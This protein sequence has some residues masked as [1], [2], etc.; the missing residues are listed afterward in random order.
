MDRG[1]SGETAVWQA[2]KWQR[3]VRDKTNCWQTS[4]RSKDDGW[5]KGTLLRFLRIAVQNWL[6]W[7]RMGIKEVTSGNVDVLF[8]TCL[9]DFRICRC[10]NVRQSANC[11]RLG[12]VVTNKLGTISELEFSMTGFTRLSP[13]FNVV[14]PISKWPG[15]LGVTNA[16]HCGGFFG[17][18]ASSLSKF[19][20]VKVVVEHGVISQNEFS[21][22]LRQ[23][24]QG[25]HQGFFG[26]RP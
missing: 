1:A 20:Q 23:F 15:I 14:I 4:Q 13:T 16:S 22:W 21:W 12:R 19:R 10:C 3:A 6:R 11:R 9:Q 17:T 18:Q 2:M 7:F 8:Q 24:I 26:I 5:N 25:V